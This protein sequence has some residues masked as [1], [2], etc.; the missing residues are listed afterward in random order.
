MRT[1]LL[2]GVR[3]STG[4]SNIIE[5]NLAA[6]SYEQVMYVQQVWKQRR[7]LI[8]GKLPMCPGL[9]ET[10]EIIDSPKDYNLHW[11]TAPNLKHWFTMNYDKAFLAARRRKFDSFTMPLNCLRESGRLVEF[12]VFWRS[13]LQYMQCLTRAAYGRRRRKSV[14]D[15]L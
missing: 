4:V 12:L 15:Y 3:R 1:Q 5:E 8:K 10:Q 13:L 6:R 11:P 7:P 2:C 9:L 14:S